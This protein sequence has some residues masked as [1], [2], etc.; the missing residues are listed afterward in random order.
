MAMPQTLP[1]L[2]KRHGYHNYEHIFEWLRAGVVTYQGYARMIAE[3][4]GETERLALVGLSPESIEEVEFN[5]DVF[6]TT[7]AELIN[8]CLHSPLFQRRDALEGYRW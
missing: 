5:A 6:D 8:T 1:A 3:D 2:P 7:C 4:V